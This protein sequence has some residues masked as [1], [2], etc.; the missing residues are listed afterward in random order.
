MVLDAGQIVFTGSVAE[1]EASTLPVVTRLTQ[2]DNGTEFSDFYTP[3]PWDKARRPKETI[4][5]R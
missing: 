3:D 5:G 1:F 2:A 4:L